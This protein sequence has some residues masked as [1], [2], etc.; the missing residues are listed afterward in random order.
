MLVFVYE[1]MKIA[2]R[3]VL[4]LLSNIPYTSIHIRMSWT[5]TYDQLA[6][7]KFDQVLEC[8]LIIPENLNRSAFEDLQ[9]CQS[10][11]RVTLFFH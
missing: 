9:F 4:L 11:R 8:F 3:R 5:W 6:R 7:I 10:L 2:S 1:A